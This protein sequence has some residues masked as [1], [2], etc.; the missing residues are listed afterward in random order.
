[1]LPPY[2]RQI[3][4]GWHLLLKVQPGAKRNEIRGV[5]EERL[6]LS[7]IAP[8]VDNKANAALL[9]FLADWLD[10]RKSA[11]VLSSGEKN[12]EK[13]IFIP[14]EAKPNFSALLSFQAG[15]RF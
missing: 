7:M 12:R 6:R 2:I 10:V 3:D 11:L 15:S 8:A 4:T 9:E 13:K 5:S 14:T 1:M